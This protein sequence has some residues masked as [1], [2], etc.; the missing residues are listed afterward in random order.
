MVAPTRFPT[1]TP[2]GKPSAAPRV[3]VPLGPPAATPPANAWGLVHVGSGRSLLCG[4][5][6]K[7]TTG[8]CPAVRAGARVCATGVGFPFLATLAKHVVSALK[9][10][11]AACGNQ[12]C[13]RHGNARP[14]GSV[15][16]LS[17]ASAQINPPRLSKRTSAGMDVMPNLAI[18]DNV[19]ASIPTSSSASCHIDTHG[20]SSR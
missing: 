1:G 14:S 11:S 15:T 5:R 8:P 18:N 4:G 20:M 7:L 3:L 17:R 16:H 13:C 2:T 19:H 12:D 10:V 9:L 6:L